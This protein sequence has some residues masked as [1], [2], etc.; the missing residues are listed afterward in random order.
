MVAIEGGE[1]VLGRVLVFHERNNK[2]EANGV[3]V[4]SIRRWLTRTYTTPC[5]CGED[6]GCMLACIYWVSLSTPS[7]RCLLVVVRLY[8]R[9]ADELLMMIGCKTPQLA[10]T[11]A[12]L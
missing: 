8:L 7:L 12:P 9:C 11:L 6:S 10:Y 2:C 4:I 1:E 5:V 3:S